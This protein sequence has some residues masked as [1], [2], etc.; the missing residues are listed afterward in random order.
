MKYH[1]NNSWKSEVD[2]NPRKEIGVVAGDDKKTKFEP[3]AKIEMFGNEANL[4]MR[5]QG[6]PD[7]K[8]REIKVK[9]DSLEYG[10]HAKTMRTYPK[11]HNNS[12]A[13]EFEWVL[14]GRPI[15][16]TETLTLQIK[17]LEFYKQPPLNEEIAPG[18]GETVTETHHYDRDGNILAHRPE[19]IVGSYSVYLSRGKS[20]NRQSPNMAMWYALQDEYKRR[21]LGISLRAEFA[22]LSTVRQLENEISKYEALSAPE[23]KYNKTYETG[24][25]F[26]IPRPKLI[27]ANGNEAYVEDFT[28]DRENALMT[29]KYPKKFMDEATYPVVVDPTFGYTSIG[30]TGG[31]SSS[32]RVVGTIGNPGESGTMTSVSYYSQNNS[33][34]NNDTKG[35]LLLGS[36]FSTVEYGDEISVNSSTAQWWTSGGFTESIS[37][38]DYY[39]TFHVDASTG[40]RGYRYYDS[41]P[42]DSGI[43]DTETYPTATDPISS[44]NLLAQTI[45]VYATYTATGGG[46]TFTPRNN[47]VV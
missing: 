25:A 14:G 29:I 42:T 1:K 18:E 23:L 47:S 27:D 10:Y 44:P 22:H 31:T 3:Q 6:L 7:D 33:D 21:D 4:S 45:S 43:F 11:T 36:D 9:G 15:N 32:D 16:L 8:R 46:S 37:N 5:L 41:G 26:H 34:G 2:T 35:L 40:N 17:N 39:T 24:K 13:W 12:D 30:G 20:W 19:E 28:I 38:Q